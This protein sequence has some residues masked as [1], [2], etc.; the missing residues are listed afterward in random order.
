MSLSALHR[1]RAASSSNHSNQPTLG[2]WKV[3][4][5][6]KTAPPQEFR[7]KEDLSA[8]TFTENHAALIF[9]RRVTF[10]R[11]CTLSLEKGDVSSGTSVICNLF[12][13]FYRNRNRS[14]SNVQAGDSA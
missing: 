9:S 1:K 6:A 10:M 5:Q 13:Y 11:L 8:E 12:I 4:K 3:K 7:S 2:S 14:G